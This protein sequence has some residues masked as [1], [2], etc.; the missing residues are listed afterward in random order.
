MAG[1]SGKVSSGFFV[2]WGFLCAGSL[3]AGLWMLRSGLRFREAHREA[4]ATI[5]MRSRTDPGTG[6]AFRPTPHL[7]FQA[8]AKTVEAEAPRGGPYAAGQRVTVWYPVDDVTAAR[9]Q[10]DHGMLLGGI[11][12][13]AAAGLFLLV[14]ALVAIA[15]FRPNRFVRFSDS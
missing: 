9:V 15:E 1:R 2:A 11:V 8:G 6:R 4:Q 13:S 12:A 14:G 3:V 10:G 5:V 7:R